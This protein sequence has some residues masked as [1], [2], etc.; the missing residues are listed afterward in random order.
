ML[1]LD[2][3]KELSGGHIV[4]GRVGDNKSYTEKIS[5]INEDG[6]PF[7]LTGL[8][9]TFMGNTHNFQTKVIDSDGAALNDAEKG[10][11][12][13]TFPSE[14]FGV[15]GPYERAY[16]QFTN[17]N[18]VVATTGDFEVIVLDN[19][20]LNASEAE[21][22]I[23]EFNKLIE[24]LQKLQE[25]NIADLKQQQDD[26]VVELSQAF[27]GIQTDLITLEGKINSYEASINET[28][29]E[30]QGTISGAVAEALDT[31]S[32]ALDD[33]QNGNF[34][35]KEESF[36]KEESSANVIYQVIGKEKAEITF[37]LDAKSE[38][39]K[40]SSVGYTTLLSPTNVS[41]TPLTE[42]QLNNLSSLDGSLYSARDVAANYMQQLKYDCDILGFFKSLLGEKFFTIRGATTD[43]QKV[44]V[45][46]S[47]ITDFTSNV[48][49]YGSGGGI[50]KLT[51]RNWNG[52]WT[53]SDSTAANEVTRI[54]QTI[55]S[56]D[57]NWKKLINGG[58]I[59]VLSNS[60]PTISPNYSTV[61]IDYLCLDVTIELSA[62]EHF[63]YMIAAYSGENI[64]KK[65]VGLENVDN[66]GT[67][68]QAE[69]ESG[70]A[71]DKF[72]T[73]LRTKQHV[74]SRIATQAE[75][76]TGTSNS[77]V[78]TP[79][80]TKQ[81]YDQ[82]AIERPKFLSNATNFCAHRGNNAEFPENSVMALKS[83]T[84]HRFTEFDVDITK[85]GKWVVMHDDT[86]D[87]TT[88]GTGRVD[89]LTLAQ[90]RALRIDTGAGLGYLTDAEKIIP[91]MSEA[92]QYCKSAGSVP[93]VEIKSNNYTDSHLQEFI[94]VLKQA[95]ILN[96][97]CV[98]ISFDKTILER[99]RNMSN[100]IELS[101]VMNSVTQT[102]LSECIRLR[103]SADV[104]YNH[105]TVTKDMVNAFHD[106]GLQLN[107][108]TAPD[109]SFES[110]KEK[111]VD[112]ITTNSR[113]GDLRW[114]L[115]TLDSNFTHYAEGGNLRQ[116]FVEEVSPGVAKVTFTVIGGVN[117]KQTRIL[118]FPDWAT[119]LYT[120]WHLCNIR[121]S[122]GSDFATVDVYGK[123]LSADKRGVVVG[124]NWDA[125]TTWANGSF[126]YDLY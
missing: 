107:V 42:E 84:R 88:N 85:D 117:T 22:V 45:L 18:G 66:Y 21:T 64:D 33:F 113:S 116:P 110:L 49:G 27:A 100:E 9:I 4:H 57:T 98:V 95:K 31:V 124:L 118:S 44:E 104:A 69:A 94:N 92:I 32:Q 26:Y 40:V 15:A 47:L 55:E 16:F 34:W 81:F 122:S 72:M 8:T 48:Y 111:G 3:G 24:E 38:F 108:W 65:F 35:T 73:P 41:W 75:A 60:E 51:H 76:E 91:T 70:T 6:S 96:G 46:E 123:A 82:Q 103:M 52:T 17:K 109:D 62:N 112:V 11:F 93:F 80:R 74:S 58:K 37:R 87:R 99:L 77:K 5:V 126:T 125:R 12:Q 67:A 29:T 90:I 53:V 56:T 43:S 97:G 61:N 28:A 39:V 119:P 25:E 79:I 2:I 19:A 7:D 101:W 68:T 115:L 23:S 36:N 20:D 114:S 71:T 1:N 83:V 59:S 120:S 78:M 102:E 50:N 10:L 13:Y 54:G 63:E 14:A 105:A 30:V 89:S 86:V 121:T 106:N